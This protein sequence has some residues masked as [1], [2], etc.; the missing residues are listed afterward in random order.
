MEGMRV[1][2]EKPEVNVDTS[3]VGSEIPD[4][5]RDGDAV[6]AVVVD[7]DDDGA[8][9]ASLGG[10]CARVGV[11][12][13]D[14]TCASCAGGGGGDEERVER[15]AGLDEEGGDEENE[16][17]VRSWYLG[18][19]EPASRD[20]KKVEEINEA[21]GSDDNEDVVVLTQMRHL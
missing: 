1:T 18:A 16:Y 11:S 13:D 2:R 6:G 5:R 3:D 4:V 8:A 9:D 15:T 17:A 19:D 21:D 10:G 20:E 7:D 12:E 14:D